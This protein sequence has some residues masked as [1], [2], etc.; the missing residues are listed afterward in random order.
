MFES[1]TLKSHLSVNDKEMLPPMRNAWELLVEAVEI[2]PRICNS[3]SGMGSVY[4][5][6]NLSRNNR[7]CGHGPVEGIVS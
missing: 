1:V 3:S 2:S 7:T 4:Y 5:P 6:S